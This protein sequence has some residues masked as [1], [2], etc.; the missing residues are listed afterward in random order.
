MSAYNNSNINYIF[1][2]QYCDLEVPEIQEMFSKYEGPPPD[3]KCHEKYG[4][5]FKG[6][7]EIC[8]EI[9]NKQ[10][11]VVLRRVMNIPE[12]REI[13]LILYSF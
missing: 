8:R 10:V 7:D 2:I 11:R 9:I 1:K 12:N 4:W 6:F 3:S 13:L 5:L